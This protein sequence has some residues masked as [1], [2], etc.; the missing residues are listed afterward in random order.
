[1]TAPTLYQ[2]LNR[3][4][5]G[6]IIAATLKKSHAKNPQLLGK[7]LPGLKKIGKATSKVTGAIAKVAAG[8]VGIPPSAINALAKIDPVAKKKLDTALAQTNAGKTAAAIV[9]AAKNGPGQ[10]E[11]VF[12][13]IKPVYIVAGAAGLAAVIIVVTHKK[14]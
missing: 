1:M 2:L 10:K 6:R 11:N 13:N 8:M 9:D 14:K 4:P 12:S 5:Q 7:F 3:T